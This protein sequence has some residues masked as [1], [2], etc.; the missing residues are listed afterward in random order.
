MRLHDVSYTDYN[1]IGV[2]SSSLS[3]I[4]LSYTSELHDYYTEGNQ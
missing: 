2:G 4:H 3:I 1:R